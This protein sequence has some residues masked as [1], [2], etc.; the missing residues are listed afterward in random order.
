MYLFVV[1]YIYFVTLSEIF[2]VVKRGLIVLD[3]LLMLHNL[4]VAVAVACSSSS[5]S[6]SSSMQ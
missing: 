3:T 4:A 2:E 1:I 5:S 6:S